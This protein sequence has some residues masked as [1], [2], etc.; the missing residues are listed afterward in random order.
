MARRKYTR[1]LGERRYKK[2]FVLATEGAETEPRYF[3][4]F[5]ADDKVIHVQLLKGGHKSSPPQV[6]KRMDAYLRKEGL[7]PDDEAWL[8]VDTDQWTED[9]LQQLYQWSQAKENY[10]LAVSNPRFEFWLLLHF[11]DGNGVGTSRECVARLLRQLPGYEKRNVD[12]KQFTDRVAE[13]IERARRRDTPPC[14]DWPR[15]TG[16]TV[17]RLVQNLTA[18]IDA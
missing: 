14:A 8:V 6:L 9:Q 15:T 13:A 18:M 4:M 10:G 5:E 12:V 11:E 17:Y 1:P 16:T 3:K 7:R 2:L